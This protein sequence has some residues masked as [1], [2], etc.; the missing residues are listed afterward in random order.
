MTRE[1]IGIEDLLTAREVMVTEIIGSMPDAH[2]EFL[3]AFERG[4]PMWS[5]LG[6]ED[7]AG[8]PAVRWREQNLDSIGK[9]KRATLVRQLE[10]V[11]AR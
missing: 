7:A 4:E 6:L 11:L 9:E 5:S 2:R 8:L 10:Q 1:A 3:L